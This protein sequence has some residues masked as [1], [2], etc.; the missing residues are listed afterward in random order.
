MNLE[1]TKPE[2]I[3]DYFRKHT[4]GQHTSKDISIYLIDTYNFSN[5]VIRQGKTLLQVINGE[6]SSVLSEYYNVET[7]MALR[8]FT[9]TL[10]GRAYYYT[11]TENLDS[12]PVVDNDK[13]LPVQTQLD[14]FKEYQPEYDCLESEEE[15]ETPLQEISPLQE[16]IVAADKIRTFNDPFVEILNKVKVFNIDDLE[17]INIISIIDGKRITLTVANA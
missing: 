12:F 15:L 1:S 9:R 3:V 11:S 5:K 6:V 4:S 7:K 2:M 17:E 16:D 13:K 8:N 10:N 14:L